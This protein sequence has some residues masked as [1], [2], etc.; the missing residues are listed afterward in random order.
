MYDKVHMKLQNTA[1]WHKIY[2]YPII[3]KSIKTSTYISKQYPSLIKNDGE[4]RSRLAE[5]IHGFTRVR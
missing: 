2:K 3:L 1:P 5:Y 4:E